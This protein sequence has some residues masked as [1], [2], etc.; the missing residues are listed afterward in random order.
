MFKKIIGIGVATIFLAGCSASLEK[1]YSPEQAVVAYYYLGCDRNNFEDMVF[2]T[3]Q[4]TVEVNNE[5]N[6][7]VAHSELSTWKMNVTYTASGA[8]VVPEVQKDLRDNYGCPTGEIPDATIE[9]GVSD[10]TIK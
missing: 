3:N 6:F 4:W 9:T 8:L 1:P 5:T 7:V 10:G 2:D